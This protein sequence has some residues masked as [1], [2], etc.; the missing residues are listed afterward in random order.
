ML[1]MKV[2]VEVVVEEGGAAVVVVKK[3]VSGS[4]GREDGARNDEHQ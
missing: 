1:A 2:V 4:R 3:V